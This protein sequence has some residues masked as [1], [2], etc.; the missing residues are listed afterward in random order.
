MDWRQSHVLNNAH[1][2][3]SSRFYYQTI[4]SLTMVDSVLLMDVSMPRLDGVFLQSITRIY[5][6]PS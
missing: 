2:I 4:L 5:T 3:I 6:D 1:Q